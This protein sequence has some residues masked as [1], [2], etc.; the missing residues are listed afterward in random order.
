MAVH[1]LKEKY[2]QAIEKYIDYFYHILILFKSLNHKIAK[3]EKVTDKQAKELNI[4]LLLFSMVCLC[5]CVQIPL[6]P[7]RLHF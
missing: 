3:L 4:K 7:E 1:F 5:V 6:L 2:M